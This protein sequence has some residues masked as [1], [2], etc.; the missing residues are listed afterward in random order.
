MRILLIE[1]EERVADFIKRGLRAENWIVTHCASGEE[2]L[3]HL[4]EGGFDVVLLDLMLPGL[5]GQEV[6]RRARA[7]GER[8]PI[9]MLT[10]LD[11]RE[12]RIDGLRMGADDYL[13][14]PFDFDE[15]VARMQALVRRANR[16]AAESCGVLEKGAVRLDLNSLQV[17]SGEQSI[18]LTAKEREILHLLMVSDGRVLSRERILSAVWERA[19]IRLR[20][21]STFT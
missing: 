15:L 20:T 1:D 3:D 8:T 18:E 16:F 2:G 10:A 12:E 9:L 19:K 21:L 14:K 5:S 6:C 4:S 17:W 11:G 13:S 7:R